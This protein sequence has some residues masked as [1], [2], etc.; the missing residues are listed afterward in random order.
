MAVSRAALW[1][2]SSPRGGSP[3]R[4]KLVL[5]SLCF[6]SLEPQLREQG[7]PNIGWIFPPQLPQ[8]RNSKAMLRGVP[9]AAF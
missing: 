2:T 5:G 1:I 8:A 6:F 4:G 7:Q 9:L 3:G